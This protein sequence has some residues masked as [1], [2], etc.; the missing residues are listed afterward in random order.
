M[1]V[2]V[3]CNWH[4]ADMDSGAHALDKVI[5]V[6]FEGGFGGRLHTVVGEMRVSVKEKLW[7]SMGWRKEEEKEEKE[8]LQ[9]DGLVKHL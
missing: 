1:S 3:W 8:H 2:K 9:P 5:G 6:Q 7:W 4:S